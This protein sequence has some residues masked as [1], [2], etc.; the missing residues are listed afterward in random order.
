MQQAVAAL[1]AEVMAAA[2]RPAQTALQILVVVEAALELIMWLV[3]QAAP[4]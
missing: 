2:E 1:V 3:L 4:V